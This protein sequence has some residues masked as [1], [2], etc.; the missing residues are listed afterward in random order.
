MRSRIPHPDFYL[1]GV[2]RMRAEKANEEFVRFVCG[3]MPE[4]EKL[5]LFHKTMLQ[6]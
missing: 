3:L 2:I 4:K 5:K 1:R 6:F